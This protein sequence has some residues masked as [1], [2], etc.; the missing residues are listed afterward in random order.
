MLYVPESSCWQA[1]P[2]LAVTNGLKKQK[3][4]KINKVHSALTKF[5]NHWCASSCPL[6]KINKISLVLNSH[7]Q[8][9]KTM[10]INITF[11]N[12]AF[13]ETEIMDV[14]KLVHIFCQLVT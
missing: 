2:D 6:R 7:Y 1:S 4:K 12:F 11:I 9:S 5:P 8:D 10:I 3:A 13:S 14:K